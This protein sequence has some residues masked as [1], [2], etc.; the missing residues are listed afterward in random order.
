MK[1]ISLAVAALLFSGAASAVQLGSSG[2][3]NQVDCPNL[4]ED[5]SIRLTTGVVA[6][7]DCTAT[8]VAFAA[9]H[10]SGMLKSRSVTQKVVAG[11]GTDAEGEPNPDTT[12]TGCT[13]G[14]ADPD[15]ELVT[16]EGAQVPSSIS[17]AG[18]VNNEYPGTGECLVG[19]PEGVA[20]G[21]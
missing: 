7:A 17:T 11:V 13:V 14:E 18:T 6:G 15:C 2:L 1:K 9:C 4:N 10:T 12:V 20:Q 19:V 3:L 8:R 16:V 5:V 21:L